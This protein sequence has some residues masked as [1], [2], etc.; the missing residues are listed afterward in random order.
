MG[1]VARRSLG[2]IP[3]YKKLYYIHSDARSELQSQKPRW[4]KA[5]ET[6]TTTCPVHGLQPALDQTNAGAC[7]TEMVTIAFDEGT[8]SR[9][10]EIEV[11][12][13]RGGSCKACRAVE[14][15]F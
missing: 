10:L 9:I 5:C 11:R 7:S 13:T 6:F 2:R 3:R 14:A 12:A 1:K 8:T 4:K 15:L